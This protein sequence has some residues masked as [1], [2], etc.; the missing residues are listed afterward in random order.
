MHTCLDNQG[1]VIL[2]MDWFRLTLDLQYYYLGST[3]GLRL[4]QLNHGCSPF[5]AG[6]FELNS[7]NCHTTQRKPWGCDTARLL[8][9]RQR[10][11]RCRN[12]VRTTALSISKF[13]LQ[14]L[15]H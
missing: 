15:S 7:H 2:M 14:P 10:K 13:G 6:L 9:P 1:R 3:V 8:K 11:L 12:Q 4:S 5:P